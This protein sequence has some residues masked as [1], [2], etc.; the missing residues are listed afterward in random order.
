ML[1]KIQSNLVSSEKFKHNDKGFKYFV[2]YL[3]DNIIRPLSI[4]LL[5][6]I[7]YIKYFDDGKNMSFKIEDDNIFSKYKETG[8]RLKRH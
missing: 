1:L 4:V 3:D 8:T 7:R 6:M 5:Q 2:G